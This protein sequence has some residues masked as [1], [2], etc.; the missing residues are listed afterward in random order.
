MSGSE[1]LSE[2]EKREMLEDSRDVNRGR[3]F[4]AARL[5]S[6]EGSLDEYIDFLSENMKLFELAPSK[7]ITEN[8]KL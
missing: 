1:I 8:Y 7:R 5:R 3:A 4:E 6:Q 2:K